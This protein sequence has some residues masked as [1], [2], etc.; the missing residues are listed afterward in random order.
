MPWF[1]SC[2]VHPMG[3]CL[4]R[5]LVWVSEARSGRQRSELGVLHEMVLFAA[6]GCAQVP[7]PCLSTYR[8]R[9]SRFVH[10]LWLLRSGALVTSDRSW[11]LERWAPGTSCRFVRPVLFCA[12]RGSS[13]IGRSFSFFPGISRLPEP[14]PAPAFSTVGSPC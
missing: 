4:A 5:L 7:Y 13:A 6:T 10:R 12:F 8:A 11:C 3:R 14:S 1:F 2:G 9:T